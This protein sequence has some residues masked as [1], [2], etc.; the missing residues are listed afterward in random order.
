MLWEGWTDA[1]F[2]AAHTSGFE[3]L[4]T[5]CATATPERVAQ[6]CGID[7]RPTSP[8]PPAGSRPGPRIHPEAPRAP[9]LSLYCQGLNQS[10]S[11]TAKNAALIN[12]HLATGQI[13]K[14][15]AGPFSLTGQPN[16]M[17]GREVG[18]LANL[19]S[20]HR[21]L[22]NPAHRAE[23]AALWGVPDVPAA[24]GQDRGRDVPGRGRRRDQ[25]AVDRLHQPGAE[26]A[27]PGHG[28]PRAAARRVR[29][30]AGGL[31][32]HRH[33]RL[34][35]PAAARHHLGREGRHRHQ[36]RAPHQPRARAVPPPPARDGP[37][38]DWPSR[39]TSRA[40][41]TAV[42]AAPA[43]RRPTLFPYDRPAP[44]SRSGTNTANPPAAATWTSPA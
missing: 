21:D 19:L 18:G 4:A 10:S 12:L 30:G 25:G 23:V 33:L 3:A 34:R 28:A 17:G 5:W 6:V 1:G 44:P 15:G 38:H 27:R 32:H 31:C 43:C 14:P 13:G 41:G 11:G 37:R 39:W 20:A 2:I 35:R 24:P 16:A 8:P 40:A 22:A 29:G 42:A 26:P 9:T 7:P 36:Q